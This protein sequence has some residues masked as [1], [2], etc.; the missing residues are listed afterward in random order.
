MDLTA[1]LQGKNFKIWAAAFLILLLLQIALLFYFGGRKEGF[2]EDEFYTYYSTNKTAGL[3]VNDRQ[4]VERDD[5]RNDF[6]V[7]KGE[8]FRYGIV[9]QMQSWD[10]HPP[11][12]YYIFHTA[13]SLFPGTFSKWLGIG[14]NLAAFVPCFFLLAYLAYCSVAEKGREESRKRGV[15]L[16]FAVCLFWGFSAAVISGVMF[17]RMYQ[18]LTLFVLLCACLHIRAVKN[19]D[20]GP[21]FLILLAITVFLGFMTQY[22]YIIFHFFLGAGFCFLFLKEKK[23]KNLISYAASCAIG[24]A[25]AI[26]YYPS[27]LAHIFRGY[28]GT[29]AVSEFSNAGN[30]VERLRFFLQLFDQYVVNGTLA[31]IL[32]IICLLWVTVSYLKKRKRTE[33][34]DLPGEEEKKTGKAVGLLLFACL[35]YFF[36]I[37]KTALLL[38]E[39]SNRYQ[40][41]VYG[42]LLFLLLYFM[43][44]PA[45][46]LINRYGKDRQKT[47]KTKRAAALVLAAAILLIDGMALK[48]D[49][50]FFLYEEEKP[51]MEYVKEN[52]DA[53]VVV[54]YNEASPENVWR[55]S[56]ELMEFSEIYFAS[57]GNPERIVDEK[58]TGS[59]K[60][61]VYAADHEDREECL[62][63]LLQSCDNLSECRVIT[64][65]TI[66][67]LYELH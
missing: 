21:G 36:T 15:F 4:W 23:I 32:L 45:E 10:V 54:F 22:Y 14:V 30:T 44:K 59:D 61:L 52:R 37:S 7:L 49:K 3:F 9:K 17:I 43:I 19:E 33:G 47:E 12:Y 40:L 34:T 63:L 53:A 8:R 46:M 57:E 39:T 55:L 16:A 2:H 48:G 58:I 28:R 27:S 66:W 26:C 29:E 64:E 6:V 41:P 11:L 5:F 38:G 67:T 1:K 13:C 25:L 51:V 35:G 31:G 60:L 20:Y 56:N 65:K 42:I 62:N 50:V 24:L 18:W